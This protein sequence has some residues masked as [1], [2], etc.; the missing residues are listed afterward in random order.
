VDARVGRLCFPHFG[1]D[2]LD[3]FLDGLDFLF[4][5]FDLVAH[6]IIL[7]ER[8][9]RADGFFG[10]QFVYLY[11]FR[12]PYR[13]AEEDRGISLHQV[14]SVRFYR[15]LETVVV[16]EDVLSRKEARVFGKGQ[17]DRLL[18][19]HGA[20]SAAPYAAVHRHRQVRRNERGFRVAGD[21]ELSR[22]LDDPT[23]L[24]VPGQREVSRKGDVPGRVVHVDGYFLPVGNR[25]AVVGKREFARYPGY[26]RLRGIL[27]FGEDRFVMHGDGFRL[28]AGS[29]EFDPEYVHAVGARGDFL[30]G[31][32]LFA[33]DDVAGVYF[34]GKS[35]E[36]VDPESSRRNRFL[37]AE[38]ED[39]GA[40]FGGT[41]LR[42]GRFDQAPVDVA[43]HAFGFESGHG[44]FCGQRVARPHLA[45]ENERDGLVVGRDHRRRD[46][47]HAGDYP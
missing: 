27:G 26:E 5:D 47:V 19:P 2:L 9:A 11:S 34:G 21:D 10:A 8:N 15:A 24:D 25:Q 16:D 12:G 22:N 28:G 20:P 42:D 35:D 7:G 39:F 3:G 17:P 36:P 43:F 14:H 29:G 6:Q 30:Y 45:F 37:T 18:C 1:I 4:A 44:H 40:F 33:G 46:A 23:V 13:S 31:E 41:D 32:Y 38:D